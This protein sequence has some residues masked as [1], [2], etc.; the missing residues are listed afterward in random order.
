MLCADDAAWLKT[1]EG[2][3]QSEVVHILT[4]ITDILNEQ[5]NLKFNWVPLK[6][7][8][9]QLRNSQAEIGFFQRWWQDATEAQKASWRRFVDRKQVE[10]ICGGFVQHDE[11]VTDYE[12]MINQV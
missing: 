1:M 9:F 10:F 3:Y 12:A 8:R 4:S 2:Y 11:A 6:I 5:P 7:Q